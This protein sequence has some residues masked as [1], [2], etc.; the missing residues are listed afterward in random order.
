MT[1]VSAKLNLYITLAFQDKWKW[2]FGFK[3]PSFR[4]HTGNSTWW[5][6]FAYKY[7]YESGNIKGNLK[8]WFIYMG[9]YYV[10]RQIKNEKKIMHL[11]ATDLHR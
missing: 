5:I 2:T 9:V 11:S 8:V 10:Q 3:C 7:K 1:L 6:T 4:P